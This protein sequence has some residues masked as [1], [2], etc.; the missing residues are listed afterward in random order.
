MPSTGPRLIQ[1]SWLTKNGL[2][3]SFNGLFQDECLNEHRFND[4]V[5]AK[6]INGW[7]DYNE[8]RPHYLL[9]IV[10]NTGDRSP[11]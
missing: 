6:I 4:D 9:I 1:P 11:Q 8:C 7:R 3:E 2:I 5:H 10:F